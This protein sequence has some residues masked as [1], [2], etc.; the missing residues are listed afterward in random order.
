MGNA[1]LSKQELELLVRRKAIDSVCKIIDAY[2]DM[3]RPL[4]KNSSA[5]NWTLDDMGPIIVPKKGMVIKLNPKNLMLYKSIICNIE[6][7]KLS[8]KDGA[9]FIDGKKAQT[10]KFMC[11]YY[12]MMGDNRKSTM[13]SRVWGF[14]PESNIIGK[15]QCVLF[16]NKNREFQWNRFF[17]MI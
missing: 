13:D 15:V 10:Y 2:G 8:E 11:N 7:C 4:L 3:E 6:K 12:F 14:L 17:K 9:Y 5:S 1:V 16:S